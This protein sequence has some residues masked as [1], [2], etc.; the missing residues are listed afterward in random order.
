MHSTSRAAPGAVRTAAGGVLPGVLSPLGP[1]WRLSHL[2]AGLGAA[3]GQRLGAA[4]VLSAAA[5]TA[6]VGDLWRGAK[7]TVVVMVVVLV[8]V[9]VIT[10]AYIST[11]FKRFSST[12]VKLFI[13]CRKIYVSSSLLITKSLEY[14]RNQYFNQT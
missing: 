14:P 10:A 8:T 5:T 2:Q 4:R 13:I 9:V 11:R 7:A 1:R 12:H 3:P 6:D